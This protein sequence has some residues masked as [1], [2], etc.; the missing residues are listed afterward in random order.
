MKTFQKVLLAV[1]ATIFTTQV[2]AVMYFARPYDPNAAHWLTRDPIGEQG[3][4][5]LYGFVN[6]TMA[7][8]HLTPWGCGSK[9]QEGILCRNT[10][11]N[12]ETPSGVLPP[13]G[14]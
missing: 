12:R 10:K 4:Q 8:I 5:N 3:G 7:S 1:G 9:K 13:S 6:K 11:L 14:D 2:Q